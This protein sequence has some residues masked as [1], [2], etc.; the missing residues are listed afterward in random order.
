MLINNDESFINHIEF[1]DYTGH[2]PNLCR[3]KLTLKIDGEV[4]R[5]GK[6]YCNECWNGEYSDYNYE[7][8]WK[9]GGGITAEY[10]AYSGEWIIDVDNLPEKYKA[11]ATE[12]D[13]VFNTNVPYGCCGGC[14]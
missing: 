1:V 3:G 14:I 5:F 7:D 12:I 4:V 13:E 9:S 2:F 11:Y 6:D 10:N 8:F